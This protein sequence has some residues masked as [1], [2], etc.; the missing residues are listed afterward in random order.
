MRSMLAA[1]LVCGCLAA[2]RGP[3]VEVRDW[4]GRPT[5]FIDGK[6]NALP[7]FNTFGRAAFER[8]MTLAYLNHFSVYFITP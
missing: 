3:Q 7:G 6:P 4:N 1:L 8:S 5:V 2:A